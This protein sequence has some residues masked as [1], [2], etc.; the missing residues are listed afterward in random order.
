VKQPLDK[1]VDEALQSLRVAVNARVEKEQR[2]CQLTNLPNQIALQE[3]IAGFIGSP[4]DYFVAFIEIDRFKTINDKF[5]YEAADAL[6]CNVAHVLNFNAEK[7]FGP[8]T[9]AFRQHG[10]EFFLVGPADPI[11]T[12]QLASNLDLLRQNI[13]ALSLEASTSKKRLACTV[14]IGWLHRSDLGTKTV[15]TRDVFVAA[16][17]AVANGKSS[18]RNTVARFDPTKAAEAAQTVRSECD[19][20]RAKFSID[21]QFSEYLSSLE[22]LWCPNC[23]KRSARPAMSQPEQ[24]DKSEP[25]FL[26]IEDAT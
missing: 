1:G 5:G 10:D 3:R 21:V 19:K 13:G 20:C 15:T 4:D 23:G 14:T 6:L 24:F 11:D 7:F 26:S 8:S 25:T 17:S 16:E 18:G 12:A 2:R 22:M 9:V